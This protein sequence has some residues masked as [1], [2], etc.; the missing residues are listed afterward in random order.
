M[1]SKGYDLKQLEKAIDILL[2]EKE[3]DNKYKNYQLIGNYQVF[4]ECH[5]LRD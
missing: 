2:A 5:I 1:K 3:L 4:Y